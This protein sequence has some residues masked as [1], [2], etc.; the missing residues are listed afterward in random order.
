MK[1]SWD[2]KSS[3]R[4]NMTKMGICFDANQALKH[5]SNKAIFTGRVERKPD[6]V[7]ENAT[8][9]QNNPVK[10]I[11]SAVIKRLEVKAAEARASI[12]HSFRFAKEQVRWITYCIDTH[13]D[14]FKAMAKDPKNIWQETPKQIR[15]KILKFISI[16][17][18]F[19]TYMEERC[20]LHMGEDDVAEEGQTQSSSDVE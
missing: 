15:Q 12:K 3:V 5:K 19:N 10:T 16:P 11:E 8:A 18:Q 14:D 9:H 1:E 13:G 17:E 4:T 7:H 6:S 20:L 2:N